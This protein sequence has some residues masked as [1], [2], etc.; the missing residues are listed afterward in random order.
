MTKQKLDA[1]K[2]RFGGRAQAI[3]LHKKLSLI[4]VAARCALTDGRISDVEQG[5][6]NITLGTILEL[7]KGL[8]VRPS[9]LF[10]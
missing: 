2:R 8:N 5:K 3:R 4:E 6:Y 7:A 1:E 9:R 10:S